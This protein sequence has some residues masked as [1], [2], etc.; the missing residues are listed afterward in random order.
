MTLHI[1]N[2]EHDIALA[3]GKAFFTAPHAGRQLRNDLGWLPAIWASPNDNILVNDVSHA[4]KSFQRLMA[5]IKTRNIPFI[6]RCQ[7]VSS[8]SNFLTEEPLS[9]K[10]NSYKIEPWGWD[11]SLKMQLSRLGISDQFLPSSKDIDYIRECSHRRK[12]AEILK[13]IHEHFV[14]NNDDLAEYNCNRIVGDAQECHT[15]EEVFNLSDFW[16]SIVV[17]APWSSS[18]RGVRFVKSNWSAT[19][20]GWLRN[21]L[22]N[23]GSVMVEPHYNKIIDFGMEFTSDGHGHISYLG[24]SLFHTQNGAYTGNLLATENYKRQELAR[25]LPL[26]LLD[27]VKS[28]ICEGLS[29]AFNQYEGPFGVDMM[30]VLPPKDRSED[31]RSC[32]EQPS[33]LLHPCVEINLRR[34]M[35]H[36]ALSLTKNINPMED[37]EIVRVMRIVYEDHQYKLK[38]QQ[39]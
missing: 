36:V 35:G 25:Y 2:P 7:F 26:N 17:K 28:L 20:I 13:Y 21:V 33:T 9:N 39:I 1:F 23:Q 38:L 29:D 24:L 32:G 18:G 22:A 16:K 11:A 6:P 5:A 12:S 30:V 27:Y 8:S 37:D 19:M 31:V 15:L 10:A 3:F 34:T 14:V 4:E